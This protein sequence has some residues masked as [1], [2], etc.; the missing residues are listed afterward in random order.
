MNLLIS[1]VGKRGGYIAEFFRPHLGP[2]DR[3][4]GT[5]STPWTPGFRACDASYLVPP[6]GEADYVPAVLELCERER[7]GAVICVE[8]FDLEALVPA[9]ER[10]IARGI[11]PLIPPASVADTALDKYKTF[12]FFRERGVATPRTAL[13]PAGAADFQY[14]MYVK[15]RRGAGS[16][17]VFRARSEEE[18]A[19]FFRYEPDMII[20]EEVV[21]EELNIQL[22]LDFG[23]R[24]IGICALRKR[25]MRHGETDQAETFYDRD[26]LSFGLQLG[27][28]LG[29]V[30]PMDI[31]VI[32]REEELVVLEVNPR[33]GGGY[34]VSHLAGADFPRL[35]LDLVREGRV[36][37]PSLSFSSGVVMM[38]DVRILGGEGSRFFREHLR[39][40]G[41][42]PGGSA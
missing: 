32:Q 10:F 18:L 33:F 8:D 7:I 37:R 16:A 5:A 27:E 24:P 38:K 15:P 29:G 4:I 21:G 11:V 22:C 2:G 17:H 3:I 34:P 12:E 30:G 9:R 28:M 42:G 6:A 25:G 19:V 35:L 1:C 20:Q 14:P 40:E 31:D 36:D 26:V 13:H 23:G 41:A 39:V